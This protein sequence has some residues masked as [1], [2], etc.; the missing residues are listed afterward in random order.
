M[1]CSGEIASGRARDEEKVAVR[2]GFEPT[3]PFRG[4]LL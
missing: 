1:L 4:S 3:E 2:V